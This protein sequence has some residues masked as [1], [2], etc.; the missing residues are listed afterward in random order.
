V[1]LVAYA[2][3]GCHIVAAL[4]PGR[5]MTVQCGCRWYTASEMIEHGVRLFGVGRYFWD[6]LREINPNEIRHDL[7]RPL[8]VAFF[9]RPGSGRHT[10]ARALFGT[11]E[12]ERPGR[13][14][15]FNEVDTAAVAASGTPDLAFLVINASEPDWSAER[16]EASRIAG[17]GCPLFLVLTHADRLGDAQQGMPAVRAQFPTHPAEL[18]A[19][20]DPRDAEA[21]RLR[22]LGRVVG[23]VPNLRLGL[24]HRFPIVRPIIAEQLIREI[25]RVNAQVALISALPSLVP[26]LGWVIGGVA[27]ILVLTKNQA[28][29]VF[30]LAAIF[31][32]NLD[33]RIGILK[34][35]LPVIGGAFVWRSAARLAI[36]LAPAPI[37]ALPKAAIAYVGTYVVGQTARYYYEQGH[38]PPPEVIASFRT[39]ALRRYNTVNDALKQRLG[40]DRP[41]LPTGEVSPSA[42]GHAQSA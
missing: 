34:E 35:I 33:D 22:L 11:D 37:A 29:L 12:T 18:T 8:T 3:L 30:K 40:G 38:R 17:S 27:D 2:G 42:D 39:E 26:I 7:E 36:G 15:S 20:V 23:T 24:A 6:A 5:P 1:N 9:G 10:L 13:G 41:A 16:R 28:M 31:G 14:L 32:R 19:V 21:T 4:V 25:S